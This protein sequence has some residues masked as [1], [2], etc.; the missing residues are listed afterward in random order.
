MG[1]SGLYLL[2]SI[3]EQE[4]PFHRKRRE[5]ICTMYICQQP[6]R[7]GQGIFLRLDG[8]CDRL[9]PPKKWK[10]KPGVAG[11]WPKKS[12]RLYRP[13]PPCVRPTGIFSASLPYPSLLQPSPPSFPLFVTC[14]CADNNH[15]LGQIKFN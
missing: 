3:N 5:A 9:G 11:C 10:R 7:Y 4:Q 8:G 1:G 12:P 14:S 6:D 13:D 2:Y 15:F